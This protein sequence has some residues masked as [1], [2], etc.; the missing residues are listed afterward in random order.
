MQSLKVFQGTPAGAP[1]VWSN[2]EQKNVSE[3]EGFQDFS[4]VC[5]TI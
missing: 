2:W 3:K 4:G 5:S 1:W